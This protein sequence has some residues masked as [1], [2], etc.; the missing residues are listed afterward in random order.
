MGLTQ[1]PVENVEL[2]MLIDTGARVNVIN[3]ANLA[4]IRTRLVGYIYV[5]TI[6]VVKWASECLL[7]Y[8]TALHLVLVKVINH[9]GSE[10]VSCDH[11]SKRN[12]SFMYFALCNS[13]L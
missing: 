8:S 2:D 13:P 1:I 3:E 9:I 10:D 11:L 4:R 12:L 5:D 6:P 7:C